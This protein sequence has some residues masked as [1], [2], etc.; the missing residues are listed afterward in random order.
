MGK[1][2]ICHSGSVASR[3]IT[4]IGSVMADAC[5]F[6]NTHFPTFQLSFFKGGPE[7][8]PDIKSLT[9]LFFHRPGKRPQERVRQESRKCQCSVCS[10]DPIPRDTAQNVIVIP[11]F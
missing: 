11:C 6:S 1:I 7:N 10:P 3:V 2:C 9:L 5:G 4:L 8:S